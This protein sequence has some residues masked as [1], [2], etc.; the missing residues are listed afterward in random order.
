MARGAN[1]KAGKQ[2][3]DAGRRA[4]GQ[5]RVQQLA[6]EPVDDS[7]RSHAQYWAQ[8]G[9]WRL[10]QEHGREKAGQIQAQRGAASFD[11]QRQ[12]YSRYLAEMRALAAE[13]N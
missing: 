13:G 2:D 1:L 4:G 5:A 8:L 12:S 6:L 11:G 10:V 7:G 9:W 3:G